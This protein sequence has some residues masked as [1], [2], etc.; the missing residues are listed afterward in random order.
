MVGTDSTDYEK[1]SP[2]ISQGRDRRTWKRYQT[3]N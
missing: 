1:M 2:K 3:K